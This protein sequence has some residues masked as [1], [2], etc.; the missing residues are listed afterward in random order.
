MAQN[1]QIWVFGLEVW[2][3]KLVQ[4]SRFPQFW[5]FGSFWVVSQFFIYIYIYIF[6]W[7]CVV[8]AGFGS[9]WLVSACFGSFRV[10]GSTLLWKLFHPKCLKPSMETISAEAK[11]TPGLASA[12]LKKVQIFEIF[13][14]WKK[15]LENFAAI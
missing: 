8:S 10:L 15:L 12:H 13:E 4:N 2:K 3:T 11:K 1:T 7:F 14:S 6:G 5:N 9:F